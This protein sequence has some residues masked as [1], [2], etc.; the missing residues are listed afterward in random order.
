ME[1]VYHV[2]KT[3]LARKTRQVIQ[4]VQRGQTVVV[5]HHGH[6]EA[7][8][9]DIMDY[10]LLRAVLHYHTHTPS[11]DPDEGLDDKVI[12]AQESQQERTNQVIAYYLAAAISL[13]R[14]SELLDL[15]WLD[16]RTRFLRLDIPVRTAPADPDEITSDLDNATAY[17]ASPS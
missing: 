2:P 17:A 3:E 15:P 8:I 4:A 9:M 7:A 13:G 11:I 16:L 5:E 12:V 6:P 14:A 10:Y 1:Y